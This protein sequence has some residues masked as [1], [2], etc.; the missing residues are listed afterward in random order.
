MKN[1]V[2]KGRNARQPGLAVALAHAF[3]LAL[4]A[5]VLALTAG[6]NRWNLWQLFAIA[7]FVVASDL[8][9]VRVSAS[10]LKVSGGALGSVLTAVLFGPAPAVL[11]CMLTIAVGWFRWREAPHYL[12]NNLV[13]YVWFPLASAVF[14][15]ATT[16]GLGL[17][18]QNAG[19]YLL[20][21]PT[22]AIA[23]TVNFLGVAGYQ[24]YLDRTPL[25]HKAREA[26]LPVLS[27]ELFSAVLTVAAVF[28][29]VNTGTAGIVL[30]ALML[31]IFQY[32]VGELLTSQRRAEEL[33]RRATTDEL[34]GLVNRERFTAALQ[35][36]I[37]ESGAG[38]ERFAVM[39]LDLDRFKEIN[40]TL[41]HHYG[42]VMLRD[43]GPRLAATVGEDGLVARLGGDE[44]AVLP[45]QRTADPDVL[46]EI[47]AA[48]VACVEWP[49]TIEQM[50]LEVGASIG[51]A[52][53][54]LDGEDANTL[55]R[56]ADIAMYAAKEDRADHQMFE[57]KLDRHSL[58][59]LMVLSDFK[60]ALA[61]EEFI[62]HYQP[63]VSID[64]SRPR[65]AEA[66]V[67]WQHPQ[68]G[69]LTPAQ[70]IPIVEQ[71]G[72]I[73]PL[74]RH[75]L[76]RAIAQ[77]ARWRADGHDLVV[78][79]NLSVRDLLDRGLPRH[80]EELLA[81]RGLPADA[82]QLEITESM[83]MSDPERA[84]ATVR[85]LR[86]LGVRIAVDDFGTGYSSLANLSRLAITEL[87]IDRSFTGRLLSDETDLIIVR[88]T[89]DL[90]HDLGLKVIAEGVE[91]EL[92]LK[93]LALLGCDLA[94]GH[95]ISRPLAPAAF[96]SWI[97][98][99]GAPPAQVASV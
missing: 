96:A 65:G 83:L 79:V 24:S 28:F 33:H 9:S 75:V 4:A 95:L 49:L 50:T 62:V 18:D 61:S 14:F 27:A 70:F 59:R 36:L 64:G 57:P 31:A 29:V 66:L 10:R 80:I 17:G 60:R 2:A 63:I 94:Q 40:D 22:F 73:G 5:L 35:D 93:Q 43:I 34:T 26:L 89:V 87:K 7:V 1:R 56:R 38:G 69:L 21:L 74:T 68:L 44:F 11:I 45:A 84:P 8:T 91:D 20:V 48:L 86:D 99:A 90:G 32:L 42:D 52:R 55:L 16:R 67:R 88:S 37:D 78:A 47:A 77:C 13:T 71:A 81:G 92:T 3:A 54:P 39:L 46:G 15:H 98:L 76:D 6:W 19:F 30:L 82:L 97:E 53:Y 72:M 12:R 58:R 85:R 23:V 51:I 25:L 41:G